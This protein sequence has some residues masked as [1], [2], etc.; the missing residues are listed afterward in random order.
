M[1]TI[2]GLTV[3][4][5]ELPEDAV[6]AKQ[7]AIN[8]WA[9]NPEETWLLAYAFTMRELVQPILDASKAGFPTHMYVDE[10]CMKDDAKQVTIVKEL[11]A[12]GVEVTVGSSPAG[13][14]YIAHTKA[15]VGRS[16]ACWEGSTNWSESAWQQVNTAM[17]FNSPAWRD[18]IIAAFNVRVAYAWANEASDQLMAAQP[19][20]VT[21][22]A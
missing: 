3:I 14:A 17:Q 13:P 18:M 12:G 21:V 19:A 4:A 5:W 11:V 1:V 8:H 7:A 20:P 10:S 9:V 2:E 6:A 16:G 22:P 15:Y